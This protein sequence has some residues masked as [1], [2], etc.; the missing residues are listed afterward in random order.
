MKIRDISNFQK[1]DFTN[2]IEKVTFTGPNWGMHQ[3]EP[4]VKSH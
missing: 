1:S 3:M 4:F 2:G